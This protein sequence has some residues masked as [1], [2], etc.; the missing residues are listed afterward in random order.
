[1]SLLLHKSFFILENSG[2]QL[3]NFFAL[4]IE[5][6]N[7]STSPLLFFLTTKLEM[8]AIFRKNGLPSKEMCKLPLLIQ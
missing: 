8:Q 3:I 1:M 2:F 4:L 5:H 6:A 7:L